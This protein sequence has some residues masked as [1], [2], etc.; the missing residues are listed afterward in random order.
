MTRKGG[1]TNKQKKTDEEIFFI[2]I[3]QNTSKCTRL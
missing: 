3:D 2:K 1:M